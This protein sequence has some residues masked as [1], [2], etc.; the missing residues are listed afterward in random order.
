MRA[1]LIGGALAVLTLVLPGVA[2]ADTVFHLD[3]PADGATVF[4]LVEVSGYV[5]DD[6]QECGPPPSWQA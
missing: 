3:P 1:K 5:L 6:G 2:G 4:G